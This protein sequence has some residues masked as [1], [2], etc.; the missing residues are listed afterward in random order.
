MPIGVTTAG[1]KMENPFIFG[2]I[3]EQ[4]YFVDREQELSQLVRDLS[5]GQKIFLLS[6]RRF[7]KS[8]LV[9]L[10]FLQLQKRY[11]RTAIIP[12]SSYSSY[13]QFLEKYSEKVIRAAGPWE[14]VKSWIKGFL[15]DVQP[16]IAMNPTGGEITIGLNPNA[17]A[18]PGSVA[19]EIFAL[20]GELSRRGGFRMAIC[21]DEFQQIAVYDGVSVE[22]A[23]RNEIQRQRNVG[24]VFSGSQPSLMEEM[25]SSGR[26][27]H[28]AGPTMFLDK[29]SAE[30]W[31]AFI[32]AQFR[33]IRTKISTAAV[34]HVLAVADLIPYDIQRIAHELWDYAQLKKKSSL[35]LGDVETVLDDLVKGQA[36]YFERL[37]EQFSSRQ[38]ALLQA[39]AERG[40][41]TLLSESVR[42]EYRLGPAST[43]QKALQALDSQ[44]IIDRYRSAYFFL[45]PLF[46]IWIRKSIQ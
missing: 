1:S 8:S 16:R 5:D 42:E 27:F 3:V 25:L 30:A 41:T 21:L 10:T 15:Q 36:H 6:P 29:I 14:R 37:W 45:D 9:S 17:R 31:T 34:D 39:L 26:P 38:R 44:D 32:V 12:V 4:R 23:L 13:T 33:A 40:P 28:K 22:N 35:D 24:Y 11:T 19:A 7:G 43:V 2:E 18:D 20:P 46:A